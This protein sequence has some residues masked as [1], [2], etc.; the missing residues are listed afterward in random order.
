MSM[1]TRNLL[2]DTNTYDLF[3][4]LVNKKPKITSKL[5]NLF[6]HHPD[7]KL[8][9]I[10]KSEGNGIG[11]LGGGFRPGHCVNALTEARHGASA[12]RIVG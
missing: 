8:H 6:Q 1:Y 2:S 11:G 3:F 4:I 7:P 5:H 12:T 9:L 10:I